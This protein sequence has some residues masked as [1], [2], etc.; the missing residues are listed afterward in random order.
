MMKMFQA[1]IALLLFQTGYSE[2]NFKLYEDKTVEQICDL[3]LEE[4][5]YE[6]I[7]QYRLLNG[8]DEEV[9]LKLLDGPDGKLKNA[10]ILCLMGTKSR[11]GLMKII[12]MIAISSE[13]TR[14]NI[15]AAVN[16]IGVEDWR[17]IIAPKIKII[18]GDVNSPYY[19]LRNYAAGLLSEYYSEPRR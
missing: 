8:Q 7:F 16:I 5:D 18:E 12:G 9:I 1:L 6:I 17:R 11:N 13:R 15:Y 10:A 3:P 14:T 4:H 2:E 19:P